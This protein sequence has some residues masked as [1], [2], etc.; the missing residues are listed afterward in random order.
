M[1]HLVG[2]GSDIRR[3][4]S[5]VTYLHTGKLG[6]GDRSSELAGALVGRYLGSKFRHWER[7][8]YRMRQCGGPAMHQI[9]RLTIA[10]VVVA[11]ATFP[12]SVPAQIAAT[13]I[14]LTEKHVEGF[15]AAQK[16][17]S[18]LFEKIQSAA[19]SGQVNTKYQ[20]E[21]EAVTKKNGFKNF[22][23]YEAVAANISMVMAAMDPQ[24]GVFTDPR[25]AI[26]K[27][28]ENANADK[29][30]P[31]REKRLCLR[32][33]MRRSNRRSPL[34]FR[35]TSSSYRNTAT[36]SMWSTSPP[37]TAI[38]LQLRPSYAQSTNDSISII[39]NG[40]ACDFIF[41]SADAE[42]ERS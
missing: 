15:I 41:S 3:I 7:A 11:F 21:L 27:E 33:S 36:K 20:A 42:P 14:K 9:F 37:T 28:I 32:S 5:C 4:T 35:V 31:D 26:K 25:T 23:E 34:S 8:P 6:Y 38:A 19:F 16:E 24:T 22:A 40:I 13:Q 29:T 2:I 12:T 30:I 39:L 18:A 10:A 1:R 17:M